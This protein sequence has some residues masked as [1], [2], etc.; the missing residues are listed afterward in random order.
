MYFSIMLL[1]CKKAVTSTIN[2]TKKGYYNQQIKESLHDG[3]AISTDPAVV[4]GH[5]NNFFVGI[6]NSVN[7]SDVIERI[8]ELKPSS[9]TGPDKIPG[10]FLKKFKERQFTKIGTHVSKPATITTGIVQGSRLGP[11]FFGFYINDIF[12]LALNGILQLFADDGSIMYRADSLCEL[13]TKM[14]EDLI[15]FNKWLK[16]NLLV[17]NTEKTKFMIPCKS[18]RAAA[19]IRNFNIQLF[20]DGEEI[21]QNRITPYIFALNRCRRFLTQKTAEMIYFAHIHSHLTYAAPI[22]GGAQTTKLEKLRALQHKAIK[23]VYKMP[24]LTSSKL[25]FNERYLC[26][27]NIIK[28]E[29]VMFVYKVINGINRNNFVLTLV[30]DEQ[31]YETRQ[32]QN[33]YLMP[34]KTSMGNLNTINVGLGLLNKLPVDLKIEKNLVRFKTGLKA[35]IN[36][37][38]KEL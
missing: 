29:P 26:V 31:G 17:L 13:Q 12:Q 25:L 14:Q 21:H 1:E 4:A 19:S 23:A 37:R 11:S 33:F 16:T 36:E 6:G 10:K 32:R 7:N 5:F 34:F 38:Y 8:N 22:W 9:A 35:Y 15:I 2:V 20:L 27:D 24:R 28:F 18:T 3:G 30:A